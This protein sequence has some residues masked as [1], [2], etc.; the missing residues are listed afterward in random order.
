MFSASQLLGM[1]RF[2]RR[3]LDQRGRVRRNSALTAATQS[4]PMI[5]ALELRLLLSG[6]HEQA[7]LDAL[8]TALAPGNPT[9]LAAFNTALQGSTALG[10]NVAVV[11]TAMSTY[12]PGAA[13][14]GLLANLG[15]T[16]TSVG[17]LVTA[18]QGMPGVTV[19]APSDLPD[20]I[21]LHVQFQSTTVVPIPL[22]QNYGVALLDP[23]L[24]DMATTLTENLTLGTYWDAGTGAAVFYVDTASSSIAVASNATGVAPAP[25]PTLADS[26][27][28]APVLGAGAYQNYPA[29]TGWSFNGGT[30]L[31]PSISGISANGSAMNT[32]PAPQTAVLNA[33]EGSQAAFI[34]GNSSISQSLNISSAQAGNYTLAFS[35]AQR[36]YEVAVAN[37][38]NPLDITYY[39]YADRQKIQVLVDGVAVDAVTPATYA[40]T[41]YTTPVLTLTAGAHTI[42]FQGMNQD[43]NSLP[44]ESTAFLDNVRLARNP[45]AELG[46]MQTS[47]GIAAVSFAPTF[48]FSLNDQPPVDAAETAGRLTL[49]QLTSTPLSLL[50]NTLVTQANPATVT[51]GL[52]TPLAPG[53]NPIVFTWPSV[54]A[55]AAGSST[56]TTDPTLTQLN[57]LQAVDPTTLA[58]GL[59]Q[60]TADLAS[61][62]TTSTLSPA[63]PF[64]TSLPLLGKSIND[65]VDF[66]NT[67]GGSQAYGI[68]QTYLTN[69]TDPVST[70]S[71]A[72][73]VTFNSDQQLLALIQSIPGATINSLT[74]T[75]SGGQ[76]LFNLALNVSVPGTPV[77]FAGLNVSPAVNIANS[78]FPS[79]TPTVVVAMNLSFG[80][81]GNTGSFFVTAT[82]QPAVQVN[83][84]ADGTLNAPVDLGMLNVNVSGGTIHVAAQANI[85]LTDPQTD[86]PA[87]PGIITAKELQ[88]G[89]QPPSANGS[90]VVL[91]VPAAVALTGTAAVSLPL[92]VN[93]SLTGGNA[94]GLTP[95]TL[96]ISWPNVAQPKT[97]VFDTS[98]LGEYLAWNNLTSTALSG[99][100]GQVES[101]LNDAS[102][103]DALGQEVGFLGT[104]LGAG[105]TLGTTLQNTLQNFTFNDI[106][107]L[108]ATLSA[109]FGTGSN[110]V[111]LTTTANGILL[112]LG[113]QQT[114]AGN[115]GWAVDSPV[116]GAAF[117]ATGAAPVSATYRGMI[118][119]GIVLTPNVTAANQFYIQGGQGFSGQILGITETPNTALNIPDFSFE[120][121]GLAAGAAQYDP[122]GSN[123]TFVAGGQAGISS[124]GNSIQG[125]VATA[126][127]TQVGFIEGNSTGTVPDGSI[128]QLLGGWQAGGYTLTVSAAQ[129]GGNFV[130][131]DFLVQIDGVTVG[132][133][134]PA[135]TTFQDYTTAPFTVTAGTH[136][137]TFVNPNNVVSST[138]LLDN[139]R[140]VSTG[141]KGSATV[142][143]LSTTY[144]SGSDEIAATDSNGHL[145]A[146]TPATF[147]VPLGT[148]GQQILLPALLAAPGSYFGPLTFNGGAKLT[149]T[150]D[151]LPSPGAHPQVQ[152]AWSGLTEPTTP[153]VT[154][155]DLGDLST[156]TTYSAQT[157]LTGVGS[158]VTELGTWQSAPVLQASLPW[159]DKTINQVTPFIT[160]LQSVFQQIQNLAPTDAATL[161]QSIINAPQGAGFSLAQAS[162]AATANDNPAGN[163]FEYT[164]NFAI[165]QQVNEPFAVGAGYDSLLTLNNTAVHVATNFTANLTFGFN[166]TDGFYVLGTDGSATPQ[167]SVSA[168]DTSQT[169][170]DKTT[171]K[172][173]T[174]PMGATGAAVSLNASYALNLLAPGDNGQKISSLELTSGG[175]ALLQ[176]ALTGSGS[177]NLPFGL[178]LG[179]ASSTYVQ[180]AGPGI[181]STFSANWDPSQA[182]PLEFGSGNSTDP[183]AG[184]GD[185][186]FDL[187]EVVTD[188]VGPYLQS[189]AQYNPI[190]QALIN[191]LNYQIPVIGMTPAQILVQYVGDGAASNV[192]TMFQILSLISQ[193]PTNT[194]QVNL[195]TYLAGAPDTGDTGWTDGG[196]SENAGN[197]QTQINDFLTTLGSCDITMPVLSDPHGSLANTLLNKPITLIE[198]DPGY[199]HYTASYDSPRVTFP[200]ASI[201]ILS[202]NAFFQAG[203]SATLF[204]N[205]DIGLTTRGLLGQGI[206]SNGAPNLLDGFFIGNDQFGDSS[207]PYQM[208][209]TFEGHVTIG[210]EIALFGAL[211]LFS[212]S[213]SLGPEGTL[214]VKVNDVAYLPNGQ[215]AGMANYD[216]L[217][218]GDGK[219]YLDELNWIR[220]QSGLLCAVEPVASVGLQLSLN[221]VIGDPPLGFDVPVYSHDFVIADWNV[222]CRPTPATLATVTNGSLTLNPTM[223][224]TSDGGNNISAS[225]WYDSTG[226]AQGIT[227]DV[228]NKSQNFN[229][230]LAFSDLT[231]VNT[232]VLNGTNGDDTFNFDPALTLLPQAAIQYLQINT[233][234]G[235]DTADLNN[236]TTTNSN[237]LGLTINGG[238]GTDHF[239]GNYAPDTI[240][241]G[242]GVNFAYVGTG[243]GQVV[244]SSGNDTI[245]GGDGNN[246][247]YG[248]SGTSSI[249]LG[250][251]NNIVQEGPGAAQITLGNGQNLITASPLVYNAGVS[252]NGSALTGG[253]PA[254]PEGTQVGFIQGNSALSQNVSGW[255]ANTY[256]LSFQA[257]Q[258]AGNAGREDFEVLLDNTVIATIT[259]TSSTYQQYTTPTFT[260]ANGGYHFLTFKGLD[261]AGGANTAFLDNVQIAPGEGVFTTDNPAPVIADSG[262]ET[263]GLAAG[264]F[265]ANDIV[266]ITN[267]TT[268]QF[269]SPVGI[270]GWTYVAGIG[271]DTIAAGNGNNTIHGDLG[272]S[273]IKV[274]SGQ[275]IIY[276]GGAGTNAITGGGGNDIINL[277]LRTVPALDLPPGMFT[278]AAATYTVD[279]GGGNTLLDIQGN[280]TMTL[281]RNSLTVGNI[282]SPTSVVQFAGIAAL[283]LA[284]GGGTAAFDVSQWTGTPVQITGGGGSATIISTDD[285]N[286][287]LTDGSLTRSDGTSFALSGI[288]TA[289]LTGGAANN[290]FD[291]TGWHGNGTINGNG[292]SDTLVA[293]DLTTATL[294]DTL[295]QRAGAADLTLSGIAQANL[296]A[297]PGGATINAAAF[298]GNSALFGQGNGNTL[299]GS[300]GSDYIV[301]GSGTGNTLVGNGTTN[302]ELIGGTGSGDTI[303]GGSG[304]NLLVGSAGGGD[305]ITTGAGANHVYTPGANNVI[306]AQGGNAII[307][308]GSS[309][310]TVNT[311]TSTSDQVLHP[312]DS[313]TIA[314][315][316]TAPVTTD[317]WEFPAWSAIP[318][319]TLPTGTP[320]PGQWVQYGTSASGGGLSN[321]SGNALAPSMVATG[322]GAGAVQYVAWADDRNG[323]YQIYVAR[324]SVSG[325]TQLAG[326]AQG[327]G[328]S[329]GGGDCLS[330]T[331]ALDAAGN[332]LVAWTQGGDIYV[333]KFD[334]T[335][336]GGQGGWVALGSSLSAGGNSSTSQAKSPQIVNTANGPVVAWLDTSGGVANVYVREFNGTTWNAVGAGST[337]GNGVSG[338]S[339]AVPAFALATDGSSLALA[340]AQPGTAVGTSIYVLENSGAGWNALAG[341]ATGNGISGSFVAA[342]PT[343]AF[344]GGSLYAAWAANTDGT[345]N[346]VASVNAGAG[347]QALTIDTPSSAGANQVSRGAASAPVLSANGTALDLVWLEDRLPNTPGQAV[348]IYANRLVNGTFVR[349]L[350]GD[351]SQDGILGR[352]TA[353]SQAGA[354]A[355]AV[356]GAGHPFVAWGDN[357]SGSAQVY[358]LGNTLDVPQIIYVND[359]VVPAN[360]FTTA[361]SQASNTG[362]TPSSPLPS[363]QAAVN[364]AAQ[365]PGTVILVDGGSYTGFT[366]GAAANGVVLIGAADGSTAITGA[367]TITG[368]QNV[369]LQ[370]LDFAGGAALSG[371]TNITLRNITGGAGGS[372]TVAGSTNVTIDGATLVGVTLSGSA[373][374]GVTLINSSLLGTGLTVNGSVTNLLA[375]NNRL[376]ALNILNPAQGIITGNNISGGGVTINA[377]FTGSIDHN[378]IHGAVI[379]VTY[380]ATAPLNANQIFHNRTG[381][382]VTAGSGGLGFLDGSSPNYI[383]DNGTGVQLSG[384]MQGQYISTNYTGVTGSGVL[385]GT[386]LATANQIEGNTIGVNFVGTVQYNRIDFN[387]TALVV[388]NGQLVAHNLIYNNAGPNLQTL[389]AANVEIINNSFYSPNQTNILVN[390][391]STNVEIL[392][393]VLWTGAGYD[394]AI[395]AD[396]RVGFFSDYNDLYTTG[397]GEIVQYIGVAFS[398]LLDWQDTV[399][400]YDLHSI[401]TT[402]VNPTWTQPRFVNLGFGDLAV[403]PVAA[404]LRSTSPTV[405]TGDPAT[406]LS[407]PSA[408]YSNLLLNPSFESGTANWTVNTGGVAQ[409][410]NPTAF[411][412]SAYFYS[413]A[414]AAGFA[415][416]TISLTA[417]GYTATQLDA[418]SLDI[419]FGGR[420][421]AAAESPADQGQLVLT[422]LDGSGNVIGTPTV[423]SASNTT[424]R[425]ELVGTR[426]HVPVGA[427]T[428]TYRF[429]SLRESGSTDDSY[430]DGTFLY[431]LPNTVATDIGAYD[432]SYASVGQAIAE[433]IQIQSPDLY[434][435]WTL[436]GSHQILWSTFGNTGSVPVRIDLYQQTNN[437]LA[438]LLNITP[439]TADDGAYAWIPQGSGLTYGTYGLRIQV[440]LV[441]NAAIADSSTENFTI[442]ENGTTYYI[443]DGSTTGDQYTTAGGNNRATGKIAA[444][445]LPLLTTLLRTYA[446][447][448]A[449]TVYV[450]T[451]TYT[452]FA[453]IELSGN[454][455]VGSGQGVTILG[456]TQNG[457][458]ASIGTLGFTSPAVIDINDA[459]YVTLRNLTLSGGDY[460]LWIRNASSNFV[461]SYL[462]VTANLLGGLRSESNTVGL[463]LSYITASGNSGDGV[464]AGGPIASLTHST[465]FNNTADGF[466]LANAGAA[467]LTNDTAY[468]NATGLYVNNSTYPTTTMVGNANLAL[469][470]GNQFYGNVNYGINAAGYVEVDGN[471]VYGQTAATNAGINFATSASATAN[472][473]Y[474]NY[475]GMQTTGG[476]FTSNRIYGNSNI[477]LEGNSGTF[478]SNEAYDNAIGIQISLASNSTGSGPYVTNNLVYS[479]TTQGIALFGSKADAKVCNNTVYQVTGNA[480]SIAPN[481]GFGG[482]QIENNILWTQGGYDIALDPTCEVGFK[483]DYNDLYATGGGAIGLWETLAKTTLQSW[484]A[485]S[486]NDADSIAADP[487]FVNAGAGD[488]HEQSTTGSF[489]G[490]SLAPV[491]GGGNLPVAAPGT[492]MADAGESPGI[493]R[494]DAAFSF[495]NEPAPNG[496]YI[497]LGAYG[498]TA[499]ASESP[500]SYVLVLK[501]VGGVTLIEQQNAT[502]TWRSQDTTGT[503]NIDLRQGDNV[504]SIAAGVANSGSYVWTIP[505][506]LT[507][508]SGYTIRVTRNAAPSAIGTSA[509]FTINAAVY[510]FY[511]NASATAGTF[512]T[513]GGSDAN[514]GLDPADPMAT[515]QNL[516]S[517][518]HLAAGDTIYID[519]GTYNLSSNIVLTALNSGLT[520]TGVPGGGTILDRL[521]TNTGN[522]VFD[523]QTVANVTLENLTITGGYYGINA[524]YNAGSTTNLT[525]SGCAF[526]G[527]EQAGIFLVNDYST[528]YV[529]TGDVITG[530]VFHDMLVSGGHYYGY[531]ISSQGD[532]VTITNNTAYNLGTGLY[533]QSGDGST[534]SGNTLYADGTGLNAANCN[535]SGNIAHDNSTGIT[536]SGGLLSG[537]TVYHNTATYT[538]ASV[539]IYLNSGTASGNISYGQNH[540]IFI[541]GSGTVT[542]NL[543]YN[544]AT[545]GIYSN[546]GSTIN[547]NVL[548]GNGWG[549]SLS[550]SLVVENNLLYNNTLGGIT[551][552]NAY[553]AQI[554]NNTVYQTAGNAFQIVSANG[555][556]N[557]DIIRNNIFWDTAGTDI[558]I[559]ADA[560]QPVRIDY[561]DLY[562]TGT[563]S[564]GTWGSTGC[565]T[566]AAWQSGAGVDTNSISADP[567]FVN[568]A[569]GDFHEQSTNGSYHGGT[570][571]PSL[572][573]TTGL[574]QANPGTLTTDANQSPVIDRGSSA[575]SYTNEPAPNGGYVNLGAY[576]NSTQ[577][578]LSPQNYLLLI[579]PGAG[580]T[581]AAGQSLTVTW[582]DE[583]SNTPAGT[584][585]T[586]TLNLLNGSSVIVLTT[587]AADIGTYT[588]ALPPS[589]AAGTYQ[590][591][592][593]RN[594]GTNLSRTSPTFNIQAFDG[595]YYV[596]SS[597]TAGQFT[598]AGGSDANG[599]LDSAHPKATIA[600]VLSSY[601]M[602]PGNVIMVDQG[603]YTLGTNLVLTAAD[604][605]ITI[606]GVPGSTIL[607]R[608]STSSGTAVIQLNGANNV[609]LSGLSMTGAQMGIEDTNGATSTHDTVSNCIIYATAYDGLYLVNGTDSYFTLT[610]SVIHDNTWDAVQCYTVIGLTFT[611]NTLYNNR[612]LSGLAANGGTISGNTFYNYTATGNGNGALSINGTGS[613][614][615]G[616]VLVTNNIAYGNSGL[617][618]SINGDVL[619]TGNTIHGNTGTGL[620]VGSGATA[621]GNLI[622]G[623]GTG[624]SFTTGQFGKAT[625]SGNRI[626]NNAGVG[627]AA[628]NGDLVSGNTVYSN[629]SWG[630]QAGPYFGSSMTIANNLVYANTAGG[631]Y[632]SGAYEDQV[633]SNTVYQATGDAFKMDGT[634]TAAPLGISLENNIL[635]AGAGYTIDL[636]DSAQ[637]GLTSDYNDL[638][639]TTGQIARVTGEAAPPT[640]ATFTTLASWAWELGQDT[641]SI[642]ADPQFVNPAGPDGLLGYTG[643]ADHGAD[644]NFHVQS[645]SPT[646]DAGDPTAE[647]AGEP[648]LNGGR[649]NVGYDG[650]TAQAAT[651]AAATT[652]QVT[653]PVS[654]QKLQVGQP[655]TIQW[656]STGLLATQTLTEVAVGEAVAV[657]QYHAAEFQVVAP[658]SATNNTTINTSLVTNPA[659]QAV[660]QNYAYASS[661]VGNYLSYQIPVPDGTYT[662]RLDWA[663]PNIHS[664]GGRTFDVMLQG[665]VVQSAFDVYSAAG[666]TLNKAVALTFTVTAT[667]GAGI[668][669]ELKNDTSANPA[670]LNGFAITAAHAGGAATQTANIQ[671][672]TDSGNTWSTIAT[673]QPLDAQGR[674][675][676]AWTPTAQTTGSTAQI[677]VVANNVAATTGASGLFPIANSG[678][679]FYVNDASTTGDVYTT[680]IGNNANSGKS[681]SAPMASI[682]AVLNDYQPGAGATIYVD[683]GT[684]MLFHDINI[685]AVDSGVTIKGPT[686]LGTAAVIN[687]DNTA[688]VTTNGD[689]VFALQPS[690]VGVTIENL[691]ITG[692]Y[693]GIFA[694]DEIP[695]SSGITNITIANNQ[696]YANASTGI[697]NAGNYNWTI[698]GNVVHDNNGAGNQFGIY[699]SYATGT[700]SN[701]TVYNQVRTGIDFNYYN[702]S[703]V[704]GNI[705]SGNTVYGNSTG[706]YVDGAMISGNLVHDNATTGIYADSYSVLTGNT[707]W[708]QTATNAVGISV[709]GCVVSNNAVFGNYNGILANGGAATVNGNRLYSNTNYGLLL[710]SLNGS[711]YSLGIHYIATAYSNL[712]YANSVGGIFIN[713]S[714]YDLSVLNNTVYQPVGNAITMSGSTTSSY[715]DTFENN[716]LWV[717]AGF[718]MAVTTSNQT[719]LIS[720]Y[721]ILYHTG[722]NANVGTWNSTTEATLAAWQA[723]SGLDAHS[724]E[725]NPQFVDPA[726]AD[727]VL[728]YNATA[729]NGNGYDG[730]G[731][732]N[733]FVVAGSPAIATGNAAIAHPALAPAADLLGYTFNADI[734]AYAYRGTTTTPP[735]V[736]SATASS[737][738]ITVLF[739]QP[740]NDIDAA[741][742]SLYVLRG[743]G[744][745]GLFGTAD[746]V[747]Y[748]LTP[749]YQHGTDQVQLAING[750]TLPAGL[751]Q[752]TINSSANSSVH[753]LAGVAL[754]GTGGGVAGINFV[755][756][757][758]APAITWATPGAITYGTALSGTQLDATANVPGSF[759]Y[760][761]ALGTVLGAGTQTLSVTFTPTDTTDYSTMIQSVQLVVSPAT[762]TITWATPAAITYGTALSGTQ[763]DASANTSG[764]FVYAPVSGTVLGAGTQNLSVTFTPTDTTDYTTATGS[765]TLTITPATL[766][767][768]NF[769]ADDKTYDGG[770]AATLHTNSAAFSGLVNGDQLMLVTTGATGT[771]SSKNVGTGLTV[772][773]QGLTL[774]GRAAGNYTL[775]QP[776]TTASIT[777]R[778]ITVTAASNTKVYDGTTSA[779]ATPTITAGT[780]GTGDTAAFNES[781]D[782]RNVGLG[783][784]LTVAG[785]VNDGSGGNNYA[786]TFVS[787]TTGMITARALTV[788]AASNTKVYDGTTSAAATPTITAGTLGTGDTAAFNESYDTRNVGLGKTLTAAGVVNDGSG[789]NNYAVTFVSNTT[790]MITARSI[791]VTAAS[792]TKVYDGTTSAAATPTITAGT[793]G[794]GDTAAFNE[795]YETRNVGLGKTLT[796]AGVVNDGS[797]GN[798]Y[799]VTF[800]SNT[801]GMI[802][803]RSLTVTAASNTKVYDGTTSAAATPAITAGTLGTGDTAAFNESYDTRNVGLGKTLTVAGVV[804]DG[805][806][807]NNYAVTF[808]S[809]TTGMITARAL[810]VTAASNTKVYD[811]TTSAAATP[812]I[813]AGTLGTGDTAAFNESYDT[814]NVGPGKTLT[815]AGSV[816]DGNGGNNY[817]VTFVSNTTG[818]ITA[819]ALTLTAAAASKTYGLADPVLAWVLTDGS[820]L[821]PDTITGV[822]VRTTG[823]N[824]GNYP[825]SQGS[826]TAGSNYTITFVPANFTIAPANLT[827]TADPASSTYGQVTPSLTGTL[828][829]V[830]TGDGIT[831]NYTTSATQLSDPGNYAITPALQDPNGQLGNYIVTSTANI[832]TITK[833]DQT[834]T[835]NTP[836]PLTF[837][838]ALDGTQLNATVTGVIG[839]AAPGALIYTPAAG[840]VLAVGAQTLTVNAAATTDYNAA[841]ATVTQQ[842]NS[843][844]TITA[845]TTLVTGPT[846]SPTSGVPLTFTATVTPV[847]P[848][849]GIPTGTVTFFDGTTAVSAP[850]ALTNGVASFTTSTLTIGNRRLS[851]QYSGDA[852]NTASTSAVF[853]EYVG[854][855]H[856]RYVQQLYNDLLKRDA[857]PGGLAGWT[858][859]LDSGQY[860]YG[861]VATA[862]TGSREYDGDIVDGF[863]V[864]YLGRHSDPGGLTDWVNLM[865][866]GYNAEQIRAG[867]LGSPEYFGDTGGT[868]SSFVTALYQSFLNRT[869]DPGGLADWVNLLDTHQYTT[870]QVA[871][872]FLNSD[873]NRT[874]IITSFYATYMRRAPDPGGLADWKTLLANGISQPTIITAFVTAPEYFAI[875]LIT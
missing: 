470:L 71:S 448:S 866:G 392:N 229:Q 76:L 143:N 520:I 708:R 465:A 249:T 534:I 633:V 345:T 46:F 253:N 725:A 258:A 294:R 27:F 503:V 81:D 805:S 479:N 724:S 818:M 701:N 673:N 617:G 812:T 201:G 741:A 456:P 334:A 308:V 875:N 849:V 234:N 198:F 43:L 684:Y 495:S 122:T 329:N 731:D 242:S 707:V 276:A 170:N 178:Q 518:Y 149:L 318:A 333:A 867:I 264:T 300:S 171:G 516:L 870:A 141:L 39:L 630:I 838:T 507:P 622:Y 279:G 616:Q 752:L 486:N 538:N 358:M 489:H 558:S 340:W 613:G 595:I 367:V 136:E 641:H 395:A 821:S 783:K 335:T 806:G 635:W 352:P 835:W 602:Q 114:Y 158:L 193:Q 551:L 649:I 409:T 577:A 621:T 780:L 28:E 824:V 720:D 642:S 627:I 549:L 774:S 578:S 94:L 643:S 67:S 625:A 498:N 804:N 574:P 13:L 297:G 378:V 216:S 80:E 289:D 786:V 810:T 675:S 723:A 151:E 530:N 739:S 596:N 288:G 667:G 509:A 808:V 48:N 38:N 106:Q 235:N 436:T 682:E 528:N 263:P 710:E 177:L 98:T 615:A 686:A 61:A 45:G 660:Y 727:A 225:V 37:P 460:G 316:F 361:P 796:A 560:Q 722:A 30:T 683:N 325:W 93:T 241:L 302:N 840:T 212:L 172:F 487:L 222:P 390:G 454:P 768:L 326:S 429:Q 371:D 15:P 12:D 442:P 293:G 629:G 737:Q 60:V 434:V 569:A 855:S 32:T 70:A 78:A 17:D 543:V 101:V 748:S 845:T 679:S 44:A 455:A 109:Q 794:I 431:V 451:G 320:G 42:T 128:S 150:P 207:Q 511:V 798:N 420:I 443:N 548:Y 262:F 304:E 481:M 502:I 348:A 600:A 860:T 19:S 387:R 307:Y 688:D 82:G 603:T 217:G 2:V 571:A 483:S 566:L 651:S 50:V 738:Q 148:S 73:V 274:G 224:D 778:S 819:R 666:T 59:D 423:L 570:L 839:G 244:E 599:G 218:A 413:G 8:A 18:L 718:D 197:L 841:S 139:V 575:D 132:T 220:G 699:M 227:L 278:P 634:V 614:P 359:G 404:G 134:T 826:L 87:T 407:L 22:S 668:A 155:Q 100:L 75:S 360:A 205:I 743:A 269:T 466:D 425:W 183:V 323:T 284:G 370:S 204:G 179:A 533:I 7:L 732:D 763:L 110:G 521:N 382:V 815:V 837:G 192:T 809:N 587:S 535:V 248:G 597:A 54:T 338:S 213:G 716:I 33:P 88:S 640:S 35:A 315:D 452:D 64:Y 194:N 238:N 446:L 693:N 440:S 541:G 104:S 145:M 125:G 372:L 833:A 119:L 115:L 645:T 807:G 681:P 1:E 261:S 337:S 331:I 89:P 79:L 202:A 762:P 303:Q 526:Y 850:V 559:S 246:V 811:D 677:R 468:Q 664:V 339:V 759:V 57:A 868:N 756:A 453:P 162:I 859:L 772:T 843:V 215:P 377:A 553:N 414:V 831:V 223:L 766:T 206:G 16:Y 485:A 769:T 6:A 173:G 765:T 384:L 245:T 403:Y 608:G 593:I 187:G 428:V 687:R 457:A 781:Y 380:N 544:N 822:P 501:P 692:G 817:A 51:A 240:G 97:Y 482:I 851:A 510:N 776:T 792:N 512:T 5:E 394:L 77:P 670:F 861:Q 856:Q 767:V 131:E 281:T 800:V 260:I 250:N 450:D 583:L 56:L 65:L 256:T 565:G 775:I 342:E 449:D 120:T 547:G 412:G 690:A 829:G 760:S 3:W 182:Q 415:Q 124:N 497:N 441:G 140:I 842:V 116:S 117:S 328:I 744:P 813:T 694:P 696:V 561:N 488:F 873:E 386:A 40:Y 674:G 519:Q 267:L 417:T 661:G 397:T 444:A 49:A 233:L 513:A 272:G 589:L 301:G 832:L 176:P 165:S 542:D 556:T 41:S 203:L 406:D 142:G 167:I 639:S 771:F 691:A 200:V 11:G 647:F 330:P 712:I 700:I 726:G 309:G 180:G 477:G 659:P 24:V 164:L 53:A 427:R 243:N 757:F 368:A 658:Y 327:G 405:A 347:W 144:S 20:Q 157:F 283:D 174:L 353:L 424:D 344:A 350:P 255:M 702:S 280:G 863:Y 472:I 343:L 523:L 532:Q 9:G 657:G 186:K 163:A 305:T 159:I 499:Q 435:N 632:L 161:D 410:G 237:L 721:N 770:M 221:A 306:N 714:I 500:T 604:N 611:N 745:D 562:V 196:V 536:F 195:S 211:S 95:E 416:Q 825:V 830:V 755:T 540:G 803:A 146:T 742:A 369:A 751:Y 366:L 827:V 626:Y 351:A 228:A 874:D 311:G 471:T 793:L 322:S 609:T 644:D 191:A 349:Q 332:P 747:V 654:L 314:S 669:L 393:N 107:S 784:T 68:F 846:S 62:A 190:P 130:P 557:T 607:N 129:A 189:I 606:E 506:S 292:G 69:Y 160:D 362:L 623:N 232:L 680:A 209:L 385:G 112:N 546:S 475:N 166:A 869:P 208:G 753:N 537:N 254:A 858:A 814:R 411:A 764:V 754:D 761:P 476:T 494:G 341:S 374:S 118:P 646:I 531:G 31:T 505:T 581:A 396:S 375:G 624:L 138:A 257:A 324:D 563:G 508:G 259:P 491:L 612:A 709:S 379:G 685:P 695:S 572:N 853:M 181:I 797:G 735:T 834:I 47:G 697:Y 828:T 105:A 736:V 34:G 66:T 210:G 214:G 729:Q 389:G 517:A 437:G 4:R 663:E 678:N 175:L 522:F 102:G 704:S 802:T 239:Q 820:L 665:Q 671:V 168:S 734:G 126:A 99:A 321:S 638:Y 433:K 365:T 463:T 14:R 74:E 383:V 539:G 310:N 636:S 564:V 251:G 676:Y 169:F 865:Q 63:N 90:V 779:A 816:S 127:G 852:N 618:I 650:N 154:P 354:L 652:L 555:N 637:V 573:T 568:A 399:A 740:P 364:L 719:G 847:A 594:D 782:T 336:N 92:T 408:Q 459:A 493:D 787:N 773:I 576:G 96:A 421:R 285:T 419:S 199:I 524:A 295:L 490:G 26:G 270:G 299:T 585:A 86:N 113:I 156:T 346:I 598:T 83:V 799:A 226:A 672:S 871:T 152:F 648:T 656:V 462:T 628:G 480:L 23:T 588:W 586:D 286:F 445:P 703:P 447:G 290:T 469:G 862:I 296:A 504:V 291:V 864:T 313:G 439:S 273:T 108:Y 10:S 713:G 492:L 525:V 282:A 247:I 271:T 788:T 584:A 590:V 230:H 123:W 147:A 789:G 103:S 467:V 121:P 698:T 717:Q 430:L 52:A 823:Q 601:T 184:F 461:G 312:G 432:A 373:S 268:S 592:V 231:G 791:T 287:T 705:V 391:G 422:F 464:Y 527:S 29:G 418:G 398:D 552:S 401:G 355:L 545:E 750:G 605:G 357:S 381:I 137:V 591:Q 580:M 426:V 478:S 749:T 376:S 277:D 746:D 706:L 153:T 84:T 582:R 801:T 236:L 400:L 620:Q 319:A 298:T 58:L 484:T 388:Q 363:I 219:S 473:V 85:T 711:N 133:I 438:F 653:A 135:T 252:A 55:P 610:N 854:S 662:I 474:G 36:P 25:V 266:P 631:I 458:A 275:N 402:V 790:G 836:A 848:A 844:S 715:P 554:L 515:I 567:L 91:P 857:D 619:A 777:A 550:A 579:N 21:S 496:G 689:S 733:F 514:S 730:G 758:T 728:G 185:I 655:T 356:D 785:V 188:M 529:A 72:P 317:L 111:T 795:S 265:A 872:G